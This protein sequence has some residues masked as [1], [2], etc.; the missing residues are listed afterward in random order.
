MKHDSEGAILKRA[1]AYADQWRMVEGASEGKYQWVIDYA[2]TQSAESI[3]GIEYLNSKADGMVRYI[4]V[5]ITLLT[6]VLAYAVTKKTPREDILFFFPTVIAL[7]Y[8]FWSALQCTKPV[9][10]P[11]RPFI[12]QAFEH[13][14]Y[15]ESSKLY[16]LRPWMLLEFSLWLLAFKK[17]M[18]IERSLYGLLLALVW[19]IVGVLCFV[20]KEP[21]IATMSVLSFQLQYLLMAVGP[22]SVALLYLVQ[23]WKSGRPS[24]ERWARLFPETENPAKSA[25]NR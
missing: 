21:L 6:L 4:G 11:R 22:V 10:H 18:Y 3:K 5:L 23:R 14:Q 19:L 8:S 17:A 12:K 15:P 25:E 2:E 9:D 1:R 7:V 20:F 16:F 24:L 13:S